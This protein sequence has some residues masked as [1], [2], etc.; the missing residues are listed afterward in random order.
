MSTVKISQLPLLSIVNANTAQT[1]FVGV[2]VPTLATG[3]FTA[4][5]LAQGLYANEILNVGVNPVLYSNVIGQFSGDD[6]GYLQVNLQ[7]FNAN[8]SSDYV[9]SASDSDNANSYI[10][11]VICI[12]TVHH[13]IVVKVI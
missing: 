1:W 12:H 7:N 10:D 4:H 8:G 13:M 9:A 11:M 6:P 2:D 5:T 3:K